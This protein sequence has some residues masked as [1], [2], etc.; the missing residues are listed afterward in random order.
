MSILLFIL[1][2]YLTKHFHSDLI[3]RKS[4][5]LFNL[6]NSVVKSKF[7]LSIRMNLTH[8]S[9]RILIDHMMK[10]HVKL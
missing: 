8:V 2:Y 6:F 3:R 5:M 4:S 7:V 9:I 1:E 10:D